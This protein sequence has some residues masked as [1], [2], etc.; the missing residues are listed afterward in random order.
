MKLLPDGCVDAVITDIPYGEVNRDS[1]GLRNL[2]K[3][4]ADVANFQIETL[5]DTF[6]RL[7][8]GTAYVFCGTEQVSTI[9]SR[10]VSAEMLTR[11]CI[12]EKPNPSPM[13]GD[14]FWLSSIEC[15][16]FARKPRAP[17][18]EFC[19]SPVWRVNVQRDQ[20]H[21]TQKPFEL[22]ARL[23]RASTNEGATILDPFLGS[24]TTAVAAK[25]LGRHFLGFEI[26]PEYCAIAEE[27][28]R[29]VE[30]QPTLFEKKAEQLILAESKE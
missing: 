24:G 12:W 23:V 19:V 4:M 16:V 26:S 13:N 6:S 9:R 14:K 27:R 8:S 25:K 15:C 17:F 18:N 5:A 20:V 21:P 10:F 2:H 7:I 30:A 1:G 28:I 3:G 29:L 22:M 11:L